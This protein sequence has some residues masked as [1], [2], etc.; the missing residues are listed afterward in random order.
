MVVPMVLCYFVDTPWA[1]WCVFAI[2]VVVALTDFV[3]G[4]WARSTNQTTDLGAILDPIADKVLVGGVFLCFCCSRS[5]FIIVFAVILV[6]DMIINILRAR[7][8]KRNII[9]SASWLGKAKTMT[10]MVGLSLILFGRALPLF[11]EGFLSC[12]SG[13]AWGVGIISF[14]ISFM[15]TIISGIDY[16]VQYHKLKS[17]RYSRHAKRPYR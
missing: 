8:A 5:W 1:K 2:F 9:I 6:R 13:F 3:D 11:T 16:I 7:A 14:M 12:V 15:L 17:H 10:Q 4:R